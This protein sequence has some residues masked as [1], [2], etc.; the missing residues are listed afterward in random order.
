MDINVFPV[1]VVGGVGVLTTIVIAFVCYKIG[2]NRIIRLVKEHYNLSN[3]RKQ[4]FRVVCATCN[5]QVPGG[6]PVKSTKVINGGYL[7]PIPANDDL[8]SDIQ[9]YATMSFQRKLDNDTGMTSEYLH[10]Y[11]PIM[12]TTVDIHHYDHPNLPANNNEY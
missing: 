4:A 3:N 6:K 2:Q 12:K 11:Q 8:K 1:V 9:P 10:Q 5:I 7:D